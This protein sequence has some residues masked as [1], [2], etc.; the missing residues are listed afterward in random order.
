LAPLTLLGH[1]D[2]IVAEN[3][4]LATMVSYWA[5]RCCRSRMSA[6]SLSLAGVDLKL[7]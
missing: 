7:P 2:A 6:W 4:C 1:A 5:H 3:Y